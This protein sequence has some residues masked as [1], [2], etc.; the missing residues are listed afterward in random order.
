MSKARRE[1]SA[2]KDVKRPAKQSIRRDRT[3]SA[4]P[5]ALQ[6]ASVSSP[7]EK[8]R[9]LCVDDHALLVEGLRAQFAVDGELEI[10]ARLGSA[11]GLIAE[12]DRIRPDLVLLDIEMPGPDVFETADRLHQMRP[13]VRFAFL[14]AHV[15]D[16]YLTSAYRCGASGYFTKGD[17]LEEIVSGLKRIARA[18]E[19]TFVMGSKVRERCAGPVTPAFHHTPRPAKPTAGPPATLLESLTPRE[20]EILRLIGKGLSRVEIAQ[21]LSRSAKT[22]DGHQDR[23]LRKLRLSSR[24]ELMKFAI[25]EGFAEA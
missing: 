22:I 9:V 13:D 15:R 4:G 18:A 2:Q 11:D 19:A 12:V 23:L 1:D 6:D 17:A 24:T 20:M 10:A 8:I 5:A 16:S 7:G 14:S 21:Q 3:D 25:R